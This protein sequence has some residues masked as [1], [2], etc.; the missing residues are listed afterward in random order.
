MLVYAARQNSGASRSA[1]AAPQS[2]VANPCP[3]AGASPRRTPECASIPEVAPG[4]RWPCLAAAPS[5]RISAC[6]P[7]SRSAGV[8]S[9]HAA[10]GRL[11][12]GSRIAS[13]TK[14]APE[15]NSYQPHRRWPQRRFG[16][17]SL[18][19]FATRASVPNETPKRPAT[20]CGG[21]DSAKVASDA[22]AGE[23]GHAE[24]HSLV[25]RVEHQI[26]QTAAGTR[27]PSSMRYS[28]ISR[29]RSA[30]AA[31]PRNQNRP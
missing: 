31:R 19:T 10:Q 30:N 28:R 26:W 7:V 17:L 9:D 1:P 23:A 4:R 6:R 20:D 22:V 25:V 18:P 13:G 12:D 8:P 2:D 24:H 5:R 15:K 21:S 29:P 14:A 3:N 11:K 16:A 27:R